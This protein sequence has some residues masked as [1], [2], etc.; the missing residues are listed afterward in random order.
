MK[1]T[2]ILAGMA[3]TT[4]LIF[5]GMGSSALGGGGEKSLTPPDTEIVIEG[6]KPARFNHSTHL[7][8]NI[9]CGACHHNAKHEPLTKEAIASLEG[10]DKLECAT[11]HVQGG[12]AEKFSKRKDIFHNLCKS[13]HQA[14]LDGKKGPTS[15]NDCHIKKK[16]AIEGC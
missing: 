16:K 11:C 7:A 13:C 6:K 4:F 5:C 12:P 3:V 1:R 14:G 8:L 9:A 2:R 15:C 10:A